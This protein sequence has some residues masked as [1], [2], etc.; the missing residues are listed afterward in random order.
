SGDADRTF[1]FRRI[2]IIAWLSKKIPYVFL[3]IMALLSCIPL[4][5]TAFA[6]TKEDDAF[7]LPP[8]PLHERVINLPGDPA[9]PVKLQV[10]VFMPEGNGPFPLAVLNH[11]AARKNSAVH[12]PNERYR[13]TY[14]AFYF[15]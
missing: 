9:R 8:A 10:T 1:C 14:L 5:N 2:H 4:S 6:E 11:G 15:L 3:Y 12:D 7:R 13:F